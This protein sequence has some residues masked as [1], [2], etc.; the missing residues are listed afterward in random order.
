VRLRKLSAAV[1]RIFDCAEFFPLN[2]AI[3]LAMWR[4]AGG[5]RRIGFKFAVKL[6]AL[7]RFWP[8][9]TNHKHFLFSYRLHR[10]EN[11]ITVSMRSFCLEI[12]SG[13]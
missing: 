13:W 12:S 7:L 4:R 2:V 8:D 1:N 9:S 6:L 3:A 11:V 10:N 5:G